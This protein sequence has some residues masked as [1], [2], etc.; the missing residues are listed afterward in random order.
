MFGGED[1]KKRSSRGESKCSFCDMCKKQK[2]LDYTRLQ[3]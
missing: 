2:E 1:T 3:E